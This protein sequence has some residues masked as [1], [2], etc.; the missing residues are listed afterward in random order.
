LRHD[1]LPLLEDRISPAVVSHL[2]R[3]ATMSRE[4]EAF[5]Q[6]FIQA[7][8]ST[9]VER[10]EGQIRIRCSDLLNPLPAA[11]WM[12]DAKTSEDA[13]LAVSRRLVR[14]IVDQ[15]RG[16]RRQWNAAHVARVL[17]LA[18]VGTS[19]SRLELPGVIV[20]RNF[21]W[22]QFTAA[23]EAGENVRGRR[24]TKPAVISEFSC[25]VQLG[26]AGDSTV[27]AVPEI[28]RRFR[29]K[30]VDWHQSRSDTDTGNAVDRALLVPPLVLRNW[31]PGDC[32]RPKGRLNCRKLKHFLRIKRVELAER[33]S[34]PVLTSGDM[35]VWTR[36][37]PVA[38]EFAT[39]SSTRLG[40]IIA[41][42]NL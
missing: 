23:G 21:D 7:L 15:A 35:L 1:V 2:N 33:A 38:A 16:H 4:D 39:R 17:R 19:G 3:L 41:E 26:S 24:S 28:R 9:A 29:L 11:G 8:L 20:E 27:I 13:Q 10:A 12:T 5:W 36:G 34:W 22:L 14:G 25:V 6:A 37:L 30:V 40:V 18:R 31:Q 32:L 42:E